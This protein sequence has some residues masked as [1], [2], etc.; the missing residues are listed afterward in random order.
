MK[1]RHAVLLVGSP[2]GNKSASLALGQRLLDGLAARGLQVETHSI[3]SAAFTAAK[4]DAMLHAAA[5][6]DLLVF[7]FPLYVDQL[8]APVI[9]V[10]EA[11]AERR[12][13]S[14][15]STRPLLAAIVQCGFP[16][17]RQ[18]QPAID[19]M[20]RFADLNGFTWAGALALGMGGAAGA[21]LPERPTGM[22]RHVVQALEQAAT[23]LSQGQP[24]AAATTSLMGRALMPR[25]LYTTVGNWQW[26]ASMRK[27]ANRR[28]RAVDMYAR[29]YA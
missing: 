12:A 21:A 1:P 16:E 4:A 14:G 17:T 15:S 19:I 20:R 5:A 13:A 23:E 24:I 26:K 25:W 22:L 3:L 11:L 29:P 9:P 27:A 28:G 2:R 18:N 7:S 8:P 6:A 10:L